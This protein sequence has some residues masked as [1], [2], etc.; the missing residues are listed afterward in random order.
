MSCMSFV[1]SARFYFQY[2][3]SIHERKPLVGQPVAQAFLI[4]ITRRSASSW[5]HVR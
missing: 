3:F 1:D 4:S 5:L 2:L